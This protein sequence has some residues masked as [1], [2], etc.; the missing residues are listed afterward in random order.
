MDNTVY[1]VK[2]SMGPEP[3]EGHAEGDLEWQ[4][5]DGPAGSRGSSSDYADLLKGLEDHRGFD[6]NIDEA[7]FTSEEKAI[8]ENFLAS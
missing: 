6:F 4:F 7:D 5:S 1:I 3:H 2:G 8:Y